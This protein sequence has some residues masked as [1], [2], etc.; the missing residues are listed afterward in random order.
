MRFRSIW[1]SLLLGVGVGVGLAWVA[2]TISRD[3]GGMVWMRPRPTVVPGA[4]P[5]NITWTPQI[6]FQY[7]GVDSDKD[8]E[9]EYF[10]QHVD[11]LM[12]RYGAEK[13]RDAVKAAGY[14][15]VLPQYVLM[16]QISGPGP[17]KN[18][19]QNCKNNYTALGNNVLWQ[20]NFCKAVHPNEDW[21]LHNVK[22]E[23]LYV[24]EQV[25]NGRHNT[26]YFMNPGAEGFRQ[27]WVEQIREQDA[28][29]WESFFLDNVAATYAY[30]GRRADNGDGTVAEYTSLDQ[31]QG[32]VV[33]MLREIR[34]AFPERQVWGNIIESPSTANA[35][36]RI[37]PELDGMQE[38]DFATNWLG[39]PPLS[40]EE[41]EAM[42][43]R[44]ERTLD[45]GRSVVLY[46]QGK[47]DDL[48]RMRFSLASYLLVATADNR[49]TFRYAHAGDYDKLWW[50]PE[51]D[52]Q[53]GEPSGPRYKDGDLW[54]RYFACARVT[55]DPAKQ[56]GTIELLNCAE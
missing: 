52:L 55:V 1:L 12:M 3:L 20:R 40:P 53:L 6:A 35:W 22:G 47:K 18:S 50:Y 13:T 51:Y 46:G 23:R 9:P 41:W 36:D 30:I 2:T 26:E 49:A 56:I 32:A 14:T 16:F 38:E 5:Q 24:R 48:A 28:A 44:A 31:W 33:G 15:N 10:V 43:V 54:V 34:A 45:D 27:F 25:W 8:V 7:Y 11:W 17:Y 29:N 39:R 42:I 4:P 37:R 19:E 21:F